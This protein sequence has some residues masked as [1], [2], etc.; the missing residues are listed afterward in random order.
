MKLFLLFLPSTKHL[1]PIIYKNMEGHRRRNGKTALMYTV[2][3]SFL[4]FAGTGFNLQSKSISDNLKNT[5]GSDLKIMLLN[6]L[7]G[8]NEDGM[9]KFL[10]EYMRNKPDNILDYSFVSVSI[11]R[12]P[13]F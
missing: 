3:L 1:E 5:L 10:Q 8:L 6:D 13:F 12:F 4:I 7:T 2:A 9:S 11:D